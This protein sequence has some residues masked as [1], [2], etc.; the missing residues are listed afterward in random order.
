MGSVALVAIRKDEAR[1]LSPG[2]AER[3]I[4]LSAPNM[5]EEVIEAVDYFYA[6][7]PD[8]EADCLLFLQKVKDDPN[9]LKSMSARARA[10]LISK[11]RCEKCG[12]RLVYI[13]YKEVHDELPES[14]IEILYE[15]MCQNCD[16]IRNGI[17]MLQLD[18]QYF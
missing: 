1:A 11:N 6:N 9:M 5:I 8:V 18:E 10:K 14:P 17:G 15:P 7:E 2:L 16:T 13:A 12:E 3:V 4:I